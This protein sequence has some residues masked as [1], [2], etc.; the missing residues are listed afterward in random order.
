MSSR[1]CLAPMVLT[2]VLTSACSILLSPYESSEEGSSTGPTGL[3]APMLRHVGCDWLDAS[4]LVDLSIGGNCTLDTDGDCEL[5]CSESPQSSTCLI[6]AGGAAHTSSE[7]CVMVVRSLEIKAG[8]RLNVVGTP[9][10]A[11]LSAGPVIIEGELSADAEGQSPGPGG[12]IGGGRGDGGRGPGSGLPGTNS[13]PGGGAGYGGWGGQG[14]CEGGGERGRPYGDC[15]I[16][17]LL[18]GSGGGGGAVENGVGG[19]GGGALQLFSIE[20]IEI[21]AGGVLTASG[22]NAPDIEG[23]YGVG[24]G[25]SGG[26]L[27]LEAPEVVVEGTLSA[28]G[29]RGGSLLPDGPGGASGGS[30]SEID[31]AEGECISN[32]ASGGGGGSGRV[33]IQSA[34]GVWTGGGDVSPELSGCTEHQ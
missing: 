7:M 12:W 4:D 10:V 20:S 19:G 22:G 13:K 27:F 26:T 8:G 6:P 24:G 3:R 31:G 21:A 16:L 32:A 5:D 15:L 18:G 29:G 1:R 23:S 25:G 30:G 11:I 2:V 9:A 17:E 14:G 28:E 33:F 34:G